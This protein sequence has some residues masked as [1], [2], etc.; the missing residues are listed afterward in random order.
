VELLPGASSALYGANAF[1]GILFM[2]SQS[3][4]TSQGITAYAKFGQTSQKLLGQ[5]TMLIM[6]LEWRMRL[7]QTC[8]KANFT[9]LRGTD[10][11]ATNYDDKTNVGRDRSHVNYDGINVYGDEVTT[12]IKGVAGLLSAGAISQSQFAAFNSMPNYNVSRTGYNEVD[13]TD[14][15]A[16]NTKIDFLFI[17][18]HLLM[19]LRLLYKFGLVM[20]FI[21]EQTG[22]I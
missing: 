2:T 3:P 16:S 12:N 17:T 8:R 18:S 11:Y 21:K 1:N 7:V 19:T 9:Y 4:F 22:I 10:W 6:E 14:N 13:L 15:K 20:R 5:T